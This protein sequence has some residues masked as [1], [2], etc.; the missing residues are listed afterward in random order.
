MYVYVC[1]P[2]ALY[3]AVAIIVHSLLPRGL[4]QI[5]FRLKVSDKKLS[6]TEGREYLKIIM[7]LNMR[8]C[9]REGAVTM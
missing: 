8:E 7:A 1:M 4:R 2:F 5:D 9:E 6:V 3:K